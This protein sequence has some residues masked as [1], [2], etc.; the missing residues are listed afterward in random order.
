MRLQER[1]DIGG[2]SRRSADARRGPVVAKFVQ[3]RAMQDF[4]DVTKPARDVGAIED[5]MV[6]DQLHN[7]PAG[8]W[9]DRAVGQRGRQRRDRVDLLG[10]ERA[11]TR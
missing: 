8:R 5:S 3:N 1:L 11:I 9:I 2:R 7:D 6:I 4:L 10:A